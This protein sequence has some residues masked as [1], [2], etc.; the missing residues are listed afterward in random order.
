MQTHSDAEALIFAPCLPGLRYPSVFIGSF[1]RDNVEL[2][3]SI[4]QNVTEKGKGWGPLFGKQRVTKGNRCC[5][6]VV[7]KKQKRQTDRQ[8]ET[9][10]QTDRQ[11]ETDRDR[12]T[13][14]E[15][16]RQKGGR[17]GEMGEER[18]FSNLYCSKTNRASFP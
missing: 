14:T 17:E 15:R 1:F 11:T 7:H 3:N 2:S 12:A 5:E 18:E 4:E 8:T 13:E 6:W 9:D 16:Q 10:R